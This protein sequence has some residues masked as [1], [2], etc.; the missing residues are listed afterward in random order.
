MNTERSD[1]ITNEFMN[2]NAPFKRRVLVFGRDFSAP[3]D[4]VFKQFCPSREADWINGWTVDLVYSETGYAEPLCVFRT[5]ASN[6]FGSGIWMMTNVQPNRVVEAVMLHE[7]DDFIEHMKLDLVDLGTGKTKVTWT[8][9][10]T[11]LSEKGNTVIEMVPDETPSFVEELE[12][13]LM[14]GELKS[15]PA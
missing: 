14:N 12:Y 10:L 3:P 6:L 8:I 5:P 4:I 11:A 7:T 13:F 1:N 15:L 2:R 9:T